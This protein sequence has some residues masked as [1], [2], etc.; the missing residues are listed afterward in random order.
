M[1]E[2]SE[3]FPEGWFFIKNNSNGYVLMVDNESQATGSPIVLATLRTK[4]YASQLWRHDPNGYL[5][6]KKSGQ[7]MDVAKGKPWKM[8]H[9]NHPELSAHLTF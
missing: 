2:K 9:G 8:L 6:N 1:F 5:V 3:K 7:V 4:D